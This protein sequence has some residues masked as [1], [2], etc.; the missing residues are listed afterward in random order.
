VSGAPSAQPVGVVGIDLGTSH[1]ALGWSLA[2]P[3]A[4][5]IS[6]QIPQWVA[7]RRRALLPLL[8]SVLYAPLPGEMPVEAAGG[9]DWLVGEYA[10]IRSQET[11]GRAI[12]SAKSWLCHPGVDRLSPILP[13]GAGELAEAAKLS[14]VEA[15]RRLLEYVRTVFEAQQPD[16]DLAQLSVVLTVPASFDQT[17]RKLTLLAA[18]RAQLRVRLLEEPQAAFYE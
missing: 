6:V 18:E 1:T 15:S 16:L 12:T 11:R 3:A 5:P 14:P 13:W 7:G 17:A 4:A 9:Q 10:R 8:P 2:G